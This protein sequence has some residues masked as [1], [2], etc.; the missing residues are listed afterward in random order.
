MFLKS[1]KLTNFRN[2][3][4]LDLSFAESTLMVGKNAQGKS[5]I[6]EAIYFLATTKSLKA[7]RDSQL[8]KQSEEVCRVEGLV[9][10]TKLEITMTSQ[11][12]VFSK[13]TQV[14]GVSRRVTDYIGNLVVIPFVPEDVN[15]VTGPP[16]LRRW[17]IDLTLASLDR[18]YKQAISSYS[19]TVTS[20]N[21]ILKGIKEGRAKIDELDFW[22]EQALQTGNLITAKRQAFFEFLNTTERKLGNYLFIYQP[23]LISKDRLRENLAREIAASATLIGPHRDDFIFRLNG[24]D[25]SVFGS[26]GE[27]RTAVLD[28]KFSELEFATKLFSTRP[29]LVLDDIFSELDEEHKRHVIAV[30]QKQ[31]TIIS[32]VEGENIPGEFLKSTQLLK[33]KEGAITT[34]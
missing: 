26:R 19:E 28:L 18:E 17:H 27:Q 4:A 1:L 34:P 5:N 16:S 12:G 20:R 31:Q 29:V 10:Q 2:I 3:P 22:T 32:A 33:I 13:R 24:R 21:R 25:L 11:D 30:T 7:D 14:N 8:I 15:L 6:L 9:D 23:S